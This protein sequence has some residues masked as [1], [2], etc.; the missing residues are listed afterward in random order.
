MTNVGSFRNSPVYLRA[1]DVSD[2]GQVLMWHNTP[3]LYDHL[4]GTFHWVSRVAEEEWLRRRC[5]Y[6]MN[7]V[8]LAVC[9]TG[10]NE[11]IGNIYLRGID[12]V[13]RHAEFHIFLGA[14]EQ[15]GHGY[16]K[17]A[18]RLA[19][20]HAFDDL[21]LLRVFLFVLASNEFAQRLYLR[22]GFKLEGR[23]RGHAFKQGQPED[24]LV[25][26]LLKSE[27][28]EKIINEDVD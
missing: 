24:V 25:M 7:E 8:N 4:G 5:A 16:G 11:H 21:G 2:L 18:T 20:N 26:G 27:W 14:Q 19:L 9:L 22:C 12:W 10:T 3:S 6:S 28:E 23:L 17:A 15:R 13:T 1:L